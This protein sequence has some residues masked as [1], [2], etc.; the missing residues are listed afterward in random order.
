[1]ITCG[2]LDEPSISALCR[3]NGLYAHH[4][5]QW[6]N[7]LVSHQTPK[8]QSETKALRQENKALKKELNRKDKALDETA[9]LLVLQKKVNAI[10]GNDAD[11]SQSKLSVQ[12]SC[13]L[14][15]R[16]KRLEPDNHWHATSL[17]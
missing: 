3:K 2:S 10:W 15:A 4:V 13:P 1:M 6:K 14:S 7:D 11:N 8:N 5:K 16:P 12:R 9:A 17:V